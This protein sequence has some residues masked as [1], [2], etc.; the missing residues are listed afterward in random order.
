MMTYQQLD[1]QLQGRC[2][3]RRKLENN[4]YAI[5]HD[6][7]ISIRLHE[8]DILTFHPN[9]RVNVTTGGWKTVTTKARL[10]EYLPHGL[11]L[12]QER[13]IWY[14]CSYRNGTWTRHGIFADGDS[15]GPKGALA[16][17]SKNSDET[18]TKKL[19]ARIN[20]FAALCASKVPLEQPGAGDCF[21]CQMVVAEGPDKGKPLAT[22]TKDT[23]HLESHMEEGYCVPSL[24]YNALKE[25]GNTDFVIGMCFDGPHRTDKLHNVSNGFNSLA[26]DRVKKCV[27]RYMLR[28]YGLAA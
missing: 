13:G 24:V 5:R 4:T 25:F 7:S 2:K 17:V 28:R 19:R 8:T 11:S 27:R 9:G 14:W 20:K 3:T 12:T 22:V 18:A 21:F 1:S 10:N 6:D 16:L 23:S 15:I 26:T